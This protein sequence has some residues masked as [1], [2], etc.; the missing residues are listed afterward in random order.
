LGSRAVVGYLYMLPAMILALGLIAYPLLYGLR[1]SLFNWNWTAG[2]ANMR[3]VGLQNYLDVLS[4]PYFANALKNTL[5]FTALSLVLEFGL[6]LATALLL[7][8]AVRGQ[9]VFRALI[10]FPLM[11]SDIVAALMWKMMLDP[12]SG[13]VNGLL[14]VAGIPGP[15]WLGNAAVVVPA[16]ALVD[17]WWQTGNIVLILLAGLQSVP[18]EPTEMAMVDGAS[19]AQLFRYLT[20]PHLIPYVKV[21]LTFRL[22]DLLRVFALS[23]AITG[24]GPVRASE[25]MQVYIYS[26]GMG[27]YLDVGYASSLA[28]T[29]AIIVGVIV[30]LF[31]RFAWRQASS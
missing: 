31:N 30:S 18:R 27:R 11:I 1:I 14:A 24:G 7:N 9:G 5:Y 12:S 17:T 10:M 23:W 16:L 25:M 22:I 2:I 13:M 29:F 26:Q 6:G 4:D 3:F 19:G 15:N 20:W 28:V 8:Q 21:A